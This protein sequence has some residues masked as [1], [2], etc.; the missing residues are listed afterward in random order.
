MRRRLAGVLAGL[1]VVVASAQ[2][3]ATEEELFDTKAA[4]A[5]L[6]KGI[7]Y[8]KAKNLDAAVDALEE[9]VSIAPE[10]EAYY[11]LGY[12]YYMK[13]RKG[14][15]ESRKKSIESFEKAYELDPTFTPSRYKPADNPAPRPEQKQPVPQDPMT[16]TTVPSKPTPETTQPSPGPGSVVKQQGQ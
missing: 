15:N 7:S 5:S 4:A 9:S 6:E 10:A 16:P 13:G 1:L 2:I 14:D 8:L 12:A 11:Y 3:A